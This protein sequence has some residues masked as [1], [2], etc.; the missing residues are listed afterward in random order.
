MLMSVGISGL[1]LMSSGLLEIFRPLPQEPSVSALGQ[2]WQGAEHGV[3]I[4][5]HQRREGDRHD[6][7]GVLLHIRP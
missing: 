3:S 5:A 2:Q 7:S 4:A 1:L 6:P